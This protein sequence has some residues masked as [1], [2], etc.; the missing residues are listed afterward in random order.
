MIREIELD[1]GA[2]LVFRGGELVALHRPERVIVADV[3]VTSTIMLFCFFAAL[4]RFRDRGSLQIHSPDG[5]F[6][7]AEEL[8]DQPL[9]H[10]HQR[11]GEDGDRRSAHG[12]TVGGGPGAT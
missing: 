12:L 5:D 7:S 1:R 6:L 3:G 10:G 8:D 11:Y 4:F 2:A 9:E